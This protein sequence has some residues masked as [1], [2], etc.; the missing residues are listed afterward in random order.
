MKNTNNFI[1]RR[2]NENK[3][4]TVDLI[5]MCNLR[6]KLYKTWKN[7]GNNTTYEMEYKQ[8]RNKINKLLH[9]KKNNYYYN[10][11]SKSRNNI[12]LTWKIINNILGKKSNNIDELITKNFKNEKTNVV[13]NF[14]QQFHENTAKIIHKCDIKTTFYSTPTM[15]NSIY[16]P[17]ADEHEIFEILKSINVN[18]GPG[19][20]NIRPADLKN[21]CNVL[22]PVI[23]KIINASISEASVP[24]VWQTSV[25]R[26]IFKN[27]KKND[28]GNYRP[29]SILPIVEK[30]ME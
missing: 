16:F 13:D 29:I 4:L 3:W 1:K 2:N 5:K 30:V 26:P 22:T 27:G 19:I 7:N 20:D 11:F 23:T 24:H 12:K 17:I 10:E 15:Q 9:V 18:K 21:N 28:F 14:S 6:D 25:I 8:L